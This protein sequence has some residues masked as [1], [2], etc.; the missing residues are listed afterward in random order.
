MAGAHHY[1]EE[2]GESAEEKAGGIIAE[3]LAK[4]G[5][6]AANLGQRR[7]GDAGK[8]RMARR[9]RRETTVSKRW[10]AEKLSMGSVSNVTYCLRGSS[11]E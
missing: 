10:I 7:K 8:V 9:L 11:K 5:W 6:K 3:E 4:L 1:G 2:I